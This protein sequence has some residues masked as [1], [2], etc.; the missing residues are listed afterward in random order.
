MK[1][2]IFNKLFKSGAPIKVTERQPISGS[3]R[4]HI[5]RY[6]GDVE[7]C[8]GVPLGEWS[9]NQM[10]AEGLNEIAKLA[11][12]NAGSA[13]AYLAVGTTTAAASLGS[14]VTGFGEVSRKTPVTNTSSNEVFYMVMTWGGAADSVTSIVMESAAMVNHA[15]SG[16]GEA[17]NIIAGVNATLADSD[18]LNL[19]AQIQVGSHNI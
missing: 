14:T 6:N 12:A 10:L 8:F 1:V 5:K 2:N 18:F 13:F 9:P 11:I 16:L 17:A 4:G 15:S 3:F 19:E 7:P